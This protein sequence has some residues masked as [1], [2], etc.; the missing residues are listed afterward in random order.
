MGLGSTILLRKR[1]WECSSLLHE[2][3]HFSAHRLLK[4]AY[5]PEKLVNT[6]APLV[7]IFSLNY[8]FGLRGCGAL[9][10]ASRSA[11]W[12]Q[13]AA[14]VSSWKVV[15]KL[16]LKP[17][18]NKTR[19]HTTKQETNKQYILEKKENQIS[20]LSNETKPNHHTSTIVLG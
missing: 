10:S 13:A 4:H 5:H 20:K 14:G 7:H 16:K 3:P 11:Q 12:T 18:T 6:L 9:L 2:F 19:K 15:R 1:G 8:I 17:W